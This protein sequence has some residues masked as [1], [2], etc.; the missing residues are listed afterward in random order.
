MANRLVL[1]MAAAAV[2]CAVSWP[3]DG[4]AQ[5]A[6]P[7]P[8]AAIMDSIAGE[9]VDHGTCVGIAIGTNL[10][11]TQ[12]FYAYG[13]VERGS[14]RRPGPAT[15][16]EIGSVTK[17]FTTTLLAILARRH[18][19]S[20]DAP[21]QNY[22]PTGVTVPAY[23]G[24]PITLAELATHTSG[25][26]RQP[27]M[28]GDS[29]SDAQMFAFLS[30]YRLRE[31]SGTH[32]LYSN[33]GVAL[34]AHALAKAAGTPWATLVERDITAKLGMPDTRLKLTDEERR[35]LAT[36]YN[37]AGGIA[38]ENMPTWPAFSGAGALF[39]TIND[40]QR[41]LAWNMGEVKSDLDDVLDELQRPR[42]PLQQPGAGMGLAWHTQPLGPGASIV[43]KNG[44]T[45]GY[46]AYIGFV[47]RA[48]T[49]IVILTNAASCPATRLGVQIL[50]TLAG[51]TPGAAESLEDE[52]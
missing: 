44:R 6:G 20:L 8:V 29:F 39:S 31:A 26:P 50:A 21:L 41:F 47:P 36:G 13:E 23:A 43:W 3:L 37:Q 24:R 25:L 42:F 16:F 51:H 18:V 11:G 4:R 40:M 7:P 9:A 35:R 10:N 46:T 15:E 19:V 45:L 28:R 49:G 17:V 34:L 5:P 2:A 33:L 30:S 38:R 14:G 32:F 27:Q 12:E 48:K 1:A 22:V 52:N